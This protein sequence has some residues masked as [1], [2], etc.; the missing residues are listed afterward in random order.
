MKYKYIGTE[1]Q[2]IEH[3]FEMEHIKYRCDDLVHG[4]KSVDDSHVLY[5]ILVY[6][7]YTEFDDEDEK[8]VQWDDDNTDDITPYIQ[9]LI[10]AN[11]VEVIA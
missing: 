4:T 5:I 3:G 1:E 7:S 11:L 6:G 2:L 10:D 9:D 8:I